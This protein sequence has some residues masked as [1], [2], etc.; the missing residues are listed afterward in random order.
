MVHWK[1]VALAWEF[2]NS[3]NNISY[4]LIDRMFYFGGHLLNHAKSPDS[5]TIIYMH[6]RIWLARWATGSNMRLKNSDAFQLVCWCYATVDVQISKA[7][8][9]KHLSEI[10]RQKAGGREGSRHLR[11]ASLCEETYDISHMHIHSVLVFLKNDTIHT[12][13]QLLPT[14]LSQTCHLHLPQNIQGTDWHTPRL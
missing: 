2:G 5:N 1:I 13:S 7:G 4:P 11:K 3:N 8:S 14:H 10:V 6:E 12:S 9:E